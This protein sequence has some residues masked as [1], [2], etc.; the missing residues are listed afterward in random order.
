MSQDAEQGE[1]TAALYAEAH[2]RIV[3][4]A[5]SLTSQELA[6]SVPST[7]G[8][9]VHDVIAHLAAITTD[10]LSGRL[11]GLPT[12][13]VTATQVEQRRGRSVDELIAEWTPNVAAMCDGA[14]AGLVPPNLAVDAVTH[15]QDIR[16]ALGRGRVP[17][18]AA[19]RFSL[20]I[21]AKGVRWRVKSGEFPAVRLVATDSDFDVTA[22]DGE[23]A[24][25]LRAPEFELFRVVSGRRGRD[26]V[27]AMDWSGECSSVLDVL[28]VFGPLPDYV[29]D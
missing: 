20:D 19:I 5:R 7:P 21:Y 13:E 8:W 2:A 28:N 26:A 23:P 16:G 15:E 22:G 14:R 11:S 24:A 17:D 18:A 1:R 4:L 10:A 29:V 6:T 9:D 25:T 27:L 3:E 12:D